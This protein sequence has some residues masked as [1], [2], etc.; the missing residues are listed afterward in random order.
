MKRK[1]EMFLT[2]E[3]K[4]LFERRWESE[5]PRCNL[6]IVHGFAE[7]SGRYDQFA[8]DLTKSGISCF[9]FDLPG[10]GKSE[11]KRGYIK[12]FNQYYNAI[13]IF[14]ERIQ[15]QKSGLPLF[16]FGH[17]LGGLLAFRFMQRL[18]PREI[19]GVILSSPLFGLAIEIPK[20]KKM[21]LPAMKFV[22]P[23]LTLYNEV[24]PNLLSH[25]QQIAKAYI[26]DPLVH[27]RASAPFFYSLLDEMGKALQ[28]APMWQGPILVQCAGE[29]KIVDIS[30]TEKVCS[31]I[32]PK[33][34]TKIQYS[35]FYH[36][37]YNE[38]ER[39]VPI[40]DLKKWLFK[41]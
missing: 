29:D 15:N 22:V 37:I 10:H 32:S 23:K 25:D 13:S 5:N 4:K 28:K 3:K 38:V 35:G 40:N 6:V 18:Q 34:I 36:E 12:D 21:M 9:S 33:W 39:E 20:I 2:S 26:N 30:A 11:G 16:L 24:D 1:E 17:S 41:E 8:S 27:K 7:H 19:K 31:V 14:I